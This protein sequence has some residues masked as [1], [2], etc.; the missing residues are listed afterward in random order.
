MWGASFLS[1]VF[2]QPYILLWG[3][4]PKSCVQINPSASEEKVELN[5]TGQ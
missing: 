1:L 3:S 4:V 2:A 5:E